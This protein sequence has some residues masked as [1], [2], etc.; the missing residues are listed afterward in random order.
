MK[1]VIMGCGRA[2]AQIA[3][4]MDAAKHKVTVIDINT[5]SFARLPPTYKGESLFGDGTDEGVLRRA[6]I[7]KADAFVA[8]TEGDNRNIMAG[9]IAKYVYHVPRVICRVYDPMRKDVYEALGL[10][11]ISPTTVFADLIASKLEMVVKEP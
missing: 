7:E 9:Q 4:I 11:A 3:S 8:V 2:G 5:T 10:E 1:I 6:G